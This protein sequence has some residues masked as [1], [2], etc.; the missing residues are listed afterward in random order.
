MSNYLRYSVDG[1]DRKIE[2]PRGNLII[3]R[4][5]DC[6]LVLTQPG[7]SR[8]HCK[9]SFEGNQHYI[10]DLQSKNGTRVNNVYVNRTK[11]K[12][13]DIIRVAEFM[14]KFG[15]EDTGSQSGSKP[16][17]TDQMVLLSE[18]KELQTEA[19]TIIRR[20][21]EF[22]DIL[23]QYDKKRET[24]QTVHPREEDSRRIMTVLIE[25]AKTLIAV[26]DLDRIIESLM[27]L[28][29]EYL[30]ADRGFL[31]LLTEEGELVPQ[32]V[33]HRDPSASDNIEI[34]KTIAVKALHEKMAILTT[35]AQVDPRFSAGDSIRFLGI[36]SAMCVPLFH[37][38]KTEGIIYL[39]SPTS[40][41]MFSD[42]D[43]D[44]LIAMANFATVGIEQAQLNKKIEQE[45][46]IRQRLAR[47]HSPS[48]V[49]KIVQ[50][51]ASDK[52]A[53]AFHLSVVEREVTV[54]FAD[55]VGF[56]PLAERLPPNQIATLLN[57][58]FSEMTNIIFRNEG[59]LDKFIGD[60]IMAIFG[61]PN[62]SDNHPFRAVK[63]AL[64]MLRQLQVINKRRAMDR[65]FAIR[66]GVNTG[67]AVAGDIGSLDRMEYTVLGNTV[68]LASRIE[69]MACKPNQVVVGEKTYLAVKDRFLSENL[70]P[71]QLKGIREK[72]NVFR[73]LSE[74]H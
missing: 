38:E 43:L 61:A 23:K 41:A 66:I 55:I 56:T 63:T 65:R 45:S 10:E 37:K 60:A 36:K 12:P 27:N 71:I 49:D 7:I 3:G 13:G 64:E 18:N 34:S 26:K 73:I 9:I 33:K 4:A 39:D 48:I 35:D 8:H 54:L 21:N 40:A 6:N 32:V 52:P 5:P 58:Y 74:R 24:E 62:P 25:V 11:L 29:F 22:Q 19:G 46:S 30:P 69:S 67:R 47:Y 51:I 72:T 16:S 57:E 68:N 50:D 2:V 20:V 59:T 70:G 44:L 17:N 1:Q 14:V 31:M 28:I 53:E 42:N 15:P